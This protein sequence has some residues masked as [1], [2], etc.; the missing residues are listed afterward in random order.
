MSN[1]PQIKDL[2]FALAH[3]LAM[4][5]LHAKH[6][7]LGQPLFENAL[8][9]AQR[10][11]DRHYI[12]PQAQI[13]DIPMGT[14]VDENGM[15]VGCT[16]PRNPMQ[17]VA[18]RTLQEQAPEPSISF[19]EDLTRLI[20]KHSAE[21]GSNTP[22]FILAQFLNQVIAAWNISTKTRDRW[23]GVEL[24]PGGSHFT[25]GGNPTGMQEG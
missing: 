24:M 16:T 15:P 11:L 5:E 19:S 22:D 1:D 4:H 21:N 7:E 23:Y 20:N 18:K 13:I 17:M 6:P 10:Q 12:E 3:V 8:E 25:N 14:M 2:R 9:M